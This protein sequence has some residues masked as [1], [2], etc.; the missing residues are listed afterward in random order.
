MLV[1]ER[2]ATALEPVDEG[3]G[4]EDAALRLRLRFASSPLRDWMFFLTQHAI[5]N[6]Q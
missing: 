4:S 6:T 1:P 2:K 5:R 3:W